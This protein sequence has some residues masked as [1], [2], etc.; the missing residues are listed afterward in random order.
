MTTGNHKSAGSLLADRCYAISRM[1][2]WITVAVVI[3]LLMI[4]LFGGIDPHGT[5]NGAFLLHS[6]LGIALYLLTISR[7]VLWLIYRPAARLIDSS[8]TT[9]GIARRLRIA[10]Y[11]L[12]IALPISGWFLASE[13]GMH[14][15]LL[16]MPALPQWY[17]EGATQHTVSSSDTPVVIVLNRIHAGLAATLFAVVAGHLLFAV[18]GRKVR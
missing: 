12:L 14:S 16:G 6:S 2:H 11:G 8:R 7:V 1:I 9:N 15:S 17:H 10:F 18:R 5:G 13:E 3:A 4:A